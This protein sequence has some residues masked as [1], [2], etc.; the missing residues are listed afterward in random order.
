MYLEGERVYL[1]N[2]IA[3]QYGY[4]G[5]YTEFHVAKKEDDLYSHKYNLVDD[6]DVVLEDVLEED[7]KKLSH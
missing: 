6:A 7:I 1:D 3:K 2:K 5:K 4:K